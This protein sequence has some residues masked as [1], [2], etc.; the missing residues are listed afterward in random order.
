MPGTH[1]TLDDME[2]IGSV[3]ADLADRNGEEP[4]IGADDR[5]HRV[6]HRLNPLPA[7][8]EDEEELAEADIL[9]ELD[10]DEEDI[11]LDG[12]DPDEPDL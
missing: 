3:F 2:P 10:L 6:V 4:A 9:H 7:R 1:D 11:D 12:F 8:E 5:E